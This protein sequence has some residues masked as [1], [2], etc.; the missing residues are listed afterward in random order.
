MLSKIL[1]D[2][3]D[4]SLVIA[5]D[6][7]DRCDDK[8]AIRILNLIKTFMNLKGCKFIIACNDEV[9][10]NYI[11]DSA[12]IDLSAKT[13]TQSE[14]DFLSK[15]FQ[16]AL[17]VS[18]SEYYDFVE[19]YD[20]LIKDAD[21]PFDPSISEIFILGKNITPRKMKRYINDLL[22]SYIL[23]ELR[24][25]QGFLTRGLVT[26]KIGFLAKIILLREEFREFYAFL[27]RDERLLDE[28]TKHLQG[29]PNRFYE[30]VSDEL[31]SA[32]IEL[33]EIIKRDLDL[34]NFLLSTAH[35]NSDN[36]S[37]FIN[38]NQNIF[39]YNISNPEVFVDRLIHG[40]FQFVD[41]FL[42]D[43]NINTSYFDFLLDL[44]LRYSK[45]QKTILVSK[46]I[47]RLI[48]NFKYA[49]V[50]QQKKIRKTIEPLMFD[51]NV[52]DN[53]DSFEEIDDL[54]NF[55]EDARTLLLNRYVAR[56]L[57]RSGVLN[58]Q[59]LNKLVTFHSFIPSESL[60]L[61]NL[62]MGQYYVNEFNQEAVDRLIQ[63][64]SMRKF[65][66]PSFTRELANHIPE[67]DFRTGKEIVLT[68]KLVNNY[69][70]LKENVSFDG[71]YI[72]SK[73]L[74]KL[75][76]GNRST[77]LNKRQVFA[78]NT[79]SR[80][81]S[82]DLNTDFIKKI[83]EELLN[84]LRRVESNVSET[85]SQLLILESLTILFDKVDTYHQDQFSVELKKALSSGMS[86]DR[87]FVMTHAP[88]LANQ[89][90]IKD[91]LK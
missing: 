30:S 72:F 71:K 51:R 32:P 57:V 5:I 88:A 2:T 87:S 1:K 29:R 50:D 76:S 54:S 67:T 44:V 25:E 41:S 9:I 75:L 12:K 55:S 86:L 31:K 68:E 4:G 8:V 38:L 18:Q 21:L 42:R 83:F 39:E 62:L 63:N 35:I 80:L 85:S 49:N 7:L 77:S 22:V 73:K 10:I 45:L 79:I 89:N 70:I 26:K 14:R 37:A 17:Y 90:S 61:I 16:T 58:S 69:V 47:H 11:R 53:I 56:T 82:N 40:D 36:V 28:T 34:C 15:F 91:L 65:F 64:S 46:C 43:P 78:V 3:H 33:Q 59:I 23:A 27:I 6:N 24:E 48:H 74:D 60:D 81:T 66:T 84:I 19:Y 52:V 13:N 20:K